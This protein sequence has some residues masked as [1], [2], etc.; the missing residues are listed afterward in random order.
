LYQDWLI[1]QV[2]VGHFWPRADASVPRT[3]QWAFGAGVQ[4]RF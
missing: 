2:L 3:R 1:G 4:M